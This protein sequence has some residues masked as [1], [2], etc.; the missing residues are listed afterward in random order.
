MC[1]ITGFA[2]ANDSAAPPLERMY[3]TLSHR[4]PDDRGIYV[5][6]DGRVGLAQCRLAVI[7]LS[8]AAHQPM[9]DASG[10]VWITFNGEIYNFKDVRRELESRG[11]RFRSASDT[12]VVVEAYCEWGEEFLSRLHGMFA[13]AIYDGGR[14]RLLLA[15]DR[16]GEKPLF[17]R[18][19]GG[20]L[21]FASELKALLADPAFPRTIDVRSLDFYLAYGYVPGEMS[22]FEGTAKLGQGEALTFDLAGGTLRKWRYWR[23]PEA[24]AAR[25][26]EEE[27]IE[28]L[29]HRLEAAVRRQLVAD[30]PVGILLSGGLDS[31]LVTAMAARVSSRPVKTFTISFPGHAGHDEAPFAR[32]VA[33][34]FGTEHAELA[35]EAATLELLPM[36]AR[37]YD[38]PIADHSMVPT[39]L[40]SRLI[41]REATVALGGDGGD[42]LFGGYH[43]YQ[44]LL[45]EE[46]LRGYA[47]RPLRRLAGAA[48]SHLLP[49]G[50][51]GRNHIIGLSNDTGYSIAH[52][53]LYFDARTRRALL[54]PHGVSLDRVPERYR[55]ALTDPDDSPLRRGMETDFR[56]TMADDY[57]VKVDRASM[58]NSL[59]IRAPFLD[60]PVVEFAF[61]RVPDELKV[62]ERERK[63]LLRRLGARL[64]PPQL[65]LTRKQGFTMP[66]DNWA[67]GEWGRFMEATLRQSDS[68]DRKTVD[69]LI[70]GQRRG[71]VG[72]HRMYALAFFELWRREYGA[73]F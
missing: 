29:D 65:D 26:S 35:A 64:L 30:V 54:R 2:L 6:A 59:E 36:L 44:W 58:L 38:E 15:R 63:I 37:Q 71:R 70:A 57:L 53:N 39:Y 23:L 48:A 73:T 19:A 4:G 17:Y 28:E 60:V 62:T 61:G 47:P 10:T 27:L 43:H 50:T 66:I 45:R 22:I 25:A 13:L 7:D 72:A 1:G 5:S 32:M 69:A 52:I 51:R 34:H 21:S 42:E 49:V 33:N 31:S 12:E 46:R 18:H 56:T 9:S 40:V 3:T 68:F 55:A 8:A 67:Q 24:G 20:K 11:R 16:A 14:R 41:R